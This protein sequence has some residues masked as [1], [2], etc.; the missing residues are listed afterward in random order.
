VTSPRVF[1]SPPAAAV[2][3]SSR[4]AALLVRRRLAAGLGLALA[5]PLAAPLAACYRNVPVDPAPLA[6]G[7]AV[8]LYLTGDGTAQLASRLGPQTLAVDGRVDSV[9]AGGVTVVVSQTTKTFGGTIAW[10]GER[11]TIPTGDIAR[12]EARVLDR[13]RTVTL[14]AGAAGVALAAM[15][16]LIAQHGSGSGQENPGGGPGPTP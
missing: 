13:R 3:R 1:P 10:M 2:P 12:A 8:R 15:A 11:V 9:G 5:A 6:P 7:S 4:R 14:A 16:A